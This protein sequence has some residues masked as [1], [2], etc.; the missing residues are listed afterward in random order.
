MKATL[1]IAAVVMLLSAGGCGQPHVVTVDNVLLSIRHQPFP[2]LDGQRTAGGAVA[3]PAL[4]VPEGDSSR[5]SNR[6]GFQTAVWF[7]VNGQDAP[8]LVNGQVEVLMYDG[9]VSADAVPTA[10]PLHVWAF[11]GN[12]LEPYAD[13]HRLL[14]WGYNFGLLEWGDDA[15]TQNRV[16][17]A[18]RYTGGDSP[19]YSAPQTVII[20]ETK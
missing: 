1:L 15:P 3:V 20:R 11:P 7:F 8:T 19:V 2:I 16:T 6:D 18:V 4:P 13:R 5:P 17:V 14:G 12:Q 10:A 9:V